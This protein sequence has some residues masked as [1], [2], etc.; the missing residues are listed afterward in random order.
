MAST[1]IH[2]I[3]SGKLVAQG[4]AKQSGSG[5]E[6]GICVYLGK[7]CFP[8]V[9]KIE[10]DMYPPSHEASV[11]TDRRLLDQSSSLLRPS[12]CLLVVARNERME[13]DMET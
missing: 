8:T 7:A 3:A 5:V 2:F 13:N 4:S 1:Q 11:R 9:C 12:L 10:T 6:H